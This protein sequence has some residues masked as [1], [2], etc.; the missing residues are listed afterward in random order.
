[1]RPP[2]IA[3]GAFGSVPRAGRIQSAGS[4][5]PRTPTWK[6][7][8][9]PGH[10]TRPFSTA[11]S[12]FCVPRAQSPPALRSVR[13]ETW[14]GPAPLRPRDP[15]ALTQGSG[16]SFPRRCRRGRRLERSVAFPLAPPSPQRPAERE[17][18]KAPLGDARDPDLWGEVGPHLPAPG[19]ASPRQHFP[20]RRGQRPRVDS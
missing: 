9:A 10:R 1:M 8:A 4:S 20:S 11:L 7:S 13:L 6:P 12:S 18:L 5:L 15:R 14:R 16:R 2:R 3:P 19:V 17:L